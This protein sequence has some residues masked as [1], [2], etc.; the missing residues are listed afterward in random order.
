MINIL[1]LEDSEDD[2]VAAIRAFA[3]SDMNITCVSNAK[4]A[5]KELAMKTYDCVVSDILMPVDDGLAFAKMLNEMNMAPKFIF[6]S[7]V[8]AFRSF[9]AYNGLKNYLGFI[10]KPTTPEKIKKLMKEF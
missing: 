4:D 10:L 9:N 5:L 1:Y 2:S 3:Y 8:P 6:T 7:G